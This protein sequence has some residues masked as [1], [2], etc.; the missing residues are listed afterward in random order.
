MPGG[1]PRPES[2]EYLEPDSPS[3]KD[4][5]VSC[6]SLY[7]SWQHYSRVMLCFCSPG[8]TSTNP[9]P[10]RWQAFNTCSVDGWMVGGWM[11]EEI[12]EQMDGWI[13]GWVL[14]SVKVLTLISLRYLTTEPGQE[15]RKCLLTRRPPAPAHLTISGTVLLSFCMCKW[16]G[17]VVPQ[18]RRSQCARA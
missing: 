10:S 8:I 9:M 18:T 3:L 5:W 14:D 17:S 16:E 7:S 6:V 1:A 4:R 2:Q 13:D 15:Q 11:D 12:E